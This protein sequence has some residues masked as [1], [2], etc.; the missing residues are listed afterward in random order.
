MTE[1]EWVSC[2]DPQPMLE[3]L[4]VLRGKGTSRRYRLFACGCCQRIRQLHD[5]ELCRV[6][7]AAAERFADGLTS[8]QELESACQAAAQTW[9]RNAGETN[10]AAILVC[11]GE[12]LYRD[13]GA[14]TAAQVADAAS[15]A[16]SMRAKKAQRHS[17]EVGE[18]CA[19][20][21]ILRCTFGALPF[22]PITLDSAWLTSNVVSL[23]NTLYEERAFER[24]PILADALEDAGCD[25]ADIL[26]HC[27]EPG[28]HVR[29]CWVVDLVLG[30]E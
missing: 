7:V 10:R 21:S 2:A 14:S 28:V 16:V 22:R 9:P 3:F 5:N 11:H 20:A 13:H 6:A 23:A 30:R 4:R 15:R 24:L 17:E 29:G 19:Q 1:G 12:L 25:N 26:N 27:R 18:R 8:E